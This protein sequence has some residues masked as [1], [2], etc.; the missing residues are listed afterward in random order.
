MSHGLPTLDSD[1]VAVGLEND[2]LVDSIAELCASLEFE[3]HRLS[4]LRVCAAGE[5]HAAQTDH[6]L[7]CRSSARVRCSP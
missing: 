2:S 3:P 7:L 1:P 4:L 6:T 5:C